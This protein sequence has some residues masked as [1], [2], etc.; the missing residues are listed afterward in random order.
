MAAMP[1]SR[2]YA[3]VLTGVLAFTSCHSIGVAHHVRT[4][5]P[6]AP[7]APSRVISTDKAADLSNVR[8][9]KA[10]VQF[11]QGMI[12]H[13]AQALDMTD[14]LRTRTIREDMRLL[15]HRIELSQ[16]DEIKMMQR[17]LEVH[18]EEVPSEHAHHAPG[19]TLMPGMLTPE[20][21]DRLSESKGTDFDRLFLEFMIKHH[22]GA[23]TMVDE[24]FSNAGAGQ[25]SQ[26]FSFASDVIADQT[27]EINRMGAMLKELEQ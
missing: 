21:M 11:I 3:A 26:I 2:R 18:G 23:L 14:L 27:A 24:L 7:G 13:H 12:H 22:S 10:D 20:E 8:P 16:A 5:Q 9:T 4:I 19:A 15:A 6:G 17:W 1:P 25:D